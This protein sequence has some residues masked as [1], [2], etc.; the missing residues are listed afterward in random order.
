M[1]TKRLLET[2]VSNLKGLRGFVEAYEE[3]AAGRMQKVRAAV[4]VA[5]QFLEGLG[6]VFAE[7]R[8]SYGREVGK[9]T[10]KSRLARNGKT[11]AVFISANSGLYGDI[12]ERVFEKFGEQ[13]ARQKAEA[14]VVGKLGLRMMQERMPDRLFNYFDFSDEEVDPE[15]LGLIMRYLLQFEK[16]LVFYG[17]FENIVTQNPTVTSVSGDEIMA[18][19]ES[20][21]A[22]EGDRGNKYLFEP[23]LAEVLQVFEG[24]ILASIFEQTVHESQLAKFASRMR[25]LDES[26][27]NIDK[28][29]VRLKFDG[30]RL[31]HKIESRKQLSRLAGI[32]LWQKT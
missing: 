22:G 10:A 26:A 29:L 5:R 23:G 24:E 1:M 31:S 13:V 3:M 18:K 27:E 17:K 8:F 11:V 20:K 6:K 14:V 9:I 4:V 25:H 16:I 19:Q 32:S 21:R 7:V 2:E 15:N 12:V 30:R 28:R